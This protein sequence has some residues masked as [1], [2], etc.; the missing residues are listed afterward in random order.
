MRIG[1]SAAMFLATSILIAGL[2]AGTAG[3]PPAKKSPAGKGFPN[4]VKDLKATPGCLGVEVARTESGKQVIFAWFEN[5]KAVLEWV[6]GD[7]HQ[8]LMSYGFPGQTFEKP[9]KDI[10]EDSGPILAIASITYAEKPKFKESTLP[11]SQ[12]AIEL[13]Q[14]MKGGVALGGTFAPAKLKV[15]GLRDYTGKK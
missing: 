15:P 14:P 10:P 1:V 11:I 8:K 13:Y 2:S 12:I 7:A 3:Q 5:K 9:L 6:E 4:L